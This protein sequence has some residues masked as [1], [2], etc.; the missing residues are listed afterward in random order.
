MGTVSSLLTTSSGALVYRD[1]ADALTGEDRSSWSEAEGGRI[2]THT[3]Y[4]PDENKRFE[5]ASEIWDGDGIV[6]MSVRQ[7]GASQY[8]ATSFVLRGHSVEDCGGAQ[9]L[10]LY[11]EGGFFIRL[12]TADRPETEGKLTDSTSDDAIE[13]A[14]IEE[15]NA[16]DPV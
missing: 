13:E 1:E 14:D 4:I 15:E 2:L 7:L 3:S 16:L 6:R 8:M 12:L 9:Y 11:G 10:R 5:L